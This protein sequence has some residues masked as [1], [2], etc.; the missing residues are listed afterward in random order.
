MEREN[1]MEKSGEMYA[2][3]QE[4]IK[5]Q[6][7]YFRL[8][9]AEKTGKIVSSLVVMSVFM[10]IGSFILMMFSLAAGMYLGK[11]FQSYPLAFLVLMGFYIVFGLV[12]YFLRHKWITTPI[13]RTIINDFFE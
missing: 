9:A 1:L 8:E 11:I 12:L 2:Y 13:I 6:I 5:L 7:E 3:V 4:Y 10:I